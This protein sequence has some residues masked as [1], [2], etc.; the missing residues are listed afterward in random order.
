MLQSTGGGTIPEIGNTG[1]YKKLNYPKQTVSS[2]PTWPLLQCC[3]QVSDPFEFLSW[4]RFKWI[5]NCRLKYTLFSSRCFCLWWCFITAIDN[6]L[7]YYVFAPL[8]LW[9]WTTT[10]TLNLWSILGGD[11]WRRI[12]RY[13]HVGGSMLERW[14]L[15]FQIPKPGPD[16]ASPCPSLSPVPPFPFPIYIS[17]SPSSCLSPACRSGHQLLA[18]SPSFLPGTHFP[19]WLILMDSASEAVNKSSI[20]CFVL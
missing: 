9:I 17:L 13:D 11:V 20:K 2:V 12:R 5:I 15:C 6:K 1:L 8:V 10:K 14:T 3:L 19:L 18:T 4:H 16:S 7:R